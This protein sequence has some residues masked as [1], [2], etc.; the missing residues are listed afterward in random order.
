M[1]VGHE[2]GASIRPIPAVDGVRSFGI[3]PR[4][5]AVSKPQ[6]RRVW[7]PLFYR[8]LGYG[9][10]PMRIKHNDNLIVLTCGRW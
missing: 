3:A 1:T 7:W 2:S 10:I 4:R 8:G 5:R 9:E 6:S